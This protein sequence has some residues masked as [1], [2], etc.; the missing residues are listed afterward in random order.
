L[1]LNDAFELQQL[2]TYPE[3][4]G[5]SWSTLDPRF[6]DH[7]L[8]R[9]IRC[10][11]ILKDTHPQ[12]KYDVF[13][14][15]NTGSVKLNPQELRHG[16]NYGALM[17]LLDELVKDEVWKQLAGIKK[18]TRMRGTELILRYLAFRHGSTPYKKPLTSFLD[19]FA[20]KA[21]NISEET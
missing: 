20:E 7:I 13:E 2:T 1:F 8:N 17:S 15:L 11:T 4:N 18:D 10:I 9:T 14:R 6:R 21:R 12:I 16:I 5:V 3:L 19:A